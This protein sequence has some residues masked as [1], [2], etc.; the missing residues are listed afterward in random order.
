LLVIGLTTFL[1]GML[2]DLINFNRQL[3]EM[4]LEKVRRLELAQSASA[5]NAKSVAD[6]VA[7]V[8]VKTAHW[9]DAPGVSAGIPTRAD[10][11]DRARVS[12]AGGRPHR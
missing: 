11:A 10:P 8:A 12:S 6:R 9:R 5:A 7:E 4:T 3:L 1:I 2:A